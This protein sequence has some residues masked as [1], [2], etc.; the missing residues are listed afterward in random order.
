MTPILTTA[1]LSLRE[2]EE[3]EAD[4]S[5]LVRLNANPNVTRYLGEGPVTVAEALGIIRERLVKQY[6]AYGVGRWGVYRREDGEFIGWAG[7]KWEPEHAH[8][9]LGYR[10]FEDV[11]GQGYGLEAASACLA[12]ADR[13]LAGKRIIGRAHPDNLASLRILER[14]GGRHIGEEI[15]PDGIVKL[16]VLRDGA[17]GAAGDKG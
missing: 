13:E 5:C 2:L 7:F 1:R 17:E 9:D 6:R 4:A 3:N 8:Y 11:W 14:I 15:E 12:W 16:L 10:F